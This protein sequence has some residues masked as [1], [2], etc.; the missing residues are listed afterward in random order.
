MSQGDENKRRRSK[1]LT[2][3]ILCIGILLIPVIYFGTYVSSVWDVYG[4][5]ENL[6]VAVVNEDKGAMYQGEEVNFGNQ[7][8]DNLKENKNLKWEF[9]DLKTAREGLE[10]GNK[11]YAVIDI[12][13]NFTEDL[14]SLSNEVK[15][16]ATITYSANQKRNYVASSI[17]TT[18]VTK[19]KDSVDLKIAEKVTDKL[20]TQLEAVPDS[21]EEA[22]DGVAK[23]KDGSE[24]LDNGYTALIDGNTTI[25]DGL[26]ALSTGLS[27]ALNGATALSNGAA[28][29]PTLVSGTKALADGAGQLKDGVAS[30][31]VLVNG[32]KQLN[33]GAKSAQAGS[34]QLAVGS[35]SVADGIK[36][37][38]SG[39]TTLNDTIQSGIKSSKDSSAAKIG[40][41]V[42]GAVNQ[43]YE[44][45]GTTPGI[46]GYVDGVNTYVNGVNTYVA[47]VNS[48]TD[49]TNKMIAALN[50]GDTATATAIA[51]Q[52]N[53]KDA[54]GMNATEKIKAGAGQLQASGT[55]VQAG[56]TSVKGSKDLLA[57]GLK[58]ALIP[59]LGNSLDT[60]AKSIGAGIQMLKTPIDGEGDTGTYTAPDGSKKTALLAG[61]TQVSQGLNTLNGGLT[62]LSQGTE[63]LSNG[64]EKLNEL[65]AGVNKLAAGADTLANGAVRLNE[66]G[67]GI[68]TLTSGIGQL[69]D[70]SVKLEDG[71]RQ[72]GDGLVTA[73]D[74]NSQVLGGLTT[75]NNG[76]N[77]SISDAR[78][79]LKTTDG[80]A[81]AVGGGVE[82]KAEP[83][84][85]IPNYGESFAPYFLNVSLWVGALTCML[86][87]YYDYKRTVK[88][89]GP[90]SRKPLIRFFF[91]LGIA[92]AQALICGLVGQFGLGLEVDLP[93]AYYLGLCAISITYM[94][95]V[96]CLMVN[97]GDVGKFLSMVLMVLQLTATGGTF[98]IELNPG[99]FRAI[100]PFLPMTYNIQ[101]M[102]EAI[103]GHNEA[104]AWY[105]FGMQFIFAAIA[106]GLLMLGNII[107]RIKNRDDG[108]KIGIKDA[109]H[110]GEEGHFSSIP[111]KH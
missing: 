90:M 50:A 89:L 26:T 62:T 16:Q 73:K 14:T 83:F 80:L 101:L 109:F 108:E 12:P 98:P 54:S 65:G 17:L 27:T 51:N 71:S 104:Y 46:N 39:L 93:L 4:K 29:L 11:Y 48:Y 24:Q 40:A 59:E 35:Q 41:G 75:L 1:Y 57:A 99:F 105:N 5:T 67:A 13:G 110:Y 86:T 33:D 25:T 22:N 100:N 21:L 28:S 70:G 102:K 103:S 9:V 3:V 78:D 15:T 38:S 31:P 49:A 30:L 79:K 2:L 94:L 42:D 7:L 6:P 44:G 47:G 34:G 8:V 107:R 82:T 95:I 20:V 87:I 85:E 52:L 96:E 68:N 81:S 77:T 72:L 74:G 19:L 32:A 60:M 91:F 45:N 64:A 66:L 97:L 106:L 37:V 84:D 63:T 76:F 53:A 36:S 58:N 43:V 23:L 55:Q 61:A 92:V 56:G 111:D 69:S 88:T 18:A 10:T